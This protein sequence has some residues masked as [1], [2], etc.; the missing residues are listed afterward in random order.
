MHL[1]QPSYGA[2]YGIFVLVSR[3][4]Y[5]YRLNGNIS[6]G[7][8][9]YLRARQINWIIIRSK[10][11]SNKFNRWDL[12]LA[13]KMV[14]WYLTLLDLISYLHHACCILQQSSPFIHLASRIGQSHGQ[15][16]TEMKIKKKY[17]VFICNAG[18][19]CG[20]A[21]FYL[22]VYGRIRAIDIVEN[23]KKKLTLG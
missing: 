16:D 14:V 6:M 19:C 1:H 17:F 5:T 15:Y 9:K 7:F 23:S 2:P 4:I 21:T 18:G 22:S 8:V 10:A 11:L 20:R 3:L 13:N 12:T